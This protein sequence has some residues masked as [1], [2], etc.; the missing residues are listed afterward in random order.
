M[1]S[2]GHGSHRVPRHPQEERVCP[3]CGRPVGTVVKRHKTLGAFVPVWE[4]GP[5]HNPD[6][7]LS[8]EKDGDASGEEVGQ[9]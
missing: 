4:P 9:T 5:C 6:C 8:V 2:E 1:D 7:P 3:A